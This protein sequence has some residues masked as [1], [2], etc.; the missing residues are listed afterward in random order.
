M[1]DQ[2]QIVTVQFTDAINKLDLDDIPDENMIGKIVSLGV[3]PDSDESLHLVVDVS[4]YEEHNKKVAA[5]NWFDENGN[6]TLT[7]FDTKWYPENGICDIYVWGTMESEIDIFIIVPG[8]SCCHG[9]DALFWQDE[10]NNA[11]IDLSGEMLVTAH[12]HSVRFHV[13]RCPKCGFVFAGQ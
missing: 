8:C 2:N 1:L 5:H 9:D 7:W 11:F 12:N 3:D 13:D 6:A 4:G 10:Q